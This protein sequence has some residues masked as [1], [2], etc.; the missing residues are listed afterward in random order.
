[1]DKYGKI[2]VRL[3]AFVAQA[4]IDSLCYEW[5]SKTYNIDIAAFLKV[6]SPIAS[7]N[8]GR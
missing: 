8:S 4:D 5:D 2:K 3:Q 7:I 6:V 1:M